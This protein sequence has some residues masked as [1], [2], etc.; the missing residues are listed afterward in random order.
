M[1]ATDKQYHASNETSARN[2][3]AVSEEMLPLWMPVDPSLL[4]ERATGAVSAITEGMPVTNRLHT[5]RKHAHDLA[6]HTK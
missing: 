3:S 1:Q 5:A 4:R 6:G 2:A